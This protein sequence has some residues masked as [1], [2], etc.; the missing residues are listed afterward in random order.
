M[1]NNQILL[2]NIFSSLFVF[3]LFAQT[4]VYYKNFVRHSEGDFCQ[5]LPPQTSFI[6]YL[7]GNVDTLL[8]ENAPRWEKN[9]DPNIPGSGV[10]GVELGNFPELTPGDSVF[11]LFTC[12]ATA[13]QGLLKSMVENIPWYYFPATV[14]L[15]SQDFPPP[16]TDLQL[17]FDDSGNRE[18]FW[19]GT[20]GVVYDIYRKALYDTVAGGE[21]RNLYIRIARNIDKSFFVDSTGGSQPHGY[22][23]ISSRKGIPG[24][25]SSEVTDYPKTPVNIRARVI[26]GTTP[27]VALSWQQPE[28]TSRIFYR[29][30][31]SQKPQFY[32]DSSNL[33]GTTPH[34]YFIDSVI[35]R[36]IVYYYRVAAVNSFGIS[37]NF[38]EPLAVKVTPP[39]TDLPDL[40]VLF[41]SRTP[42]YPRFEVEYGPPPGYNPHLKPGTEDVKHY[43]EA[44]EMIKYRAIIRNSGGETVEQF[45]IRWFVNGNTIKTDFYNLLIPGQQ[46]ISQME[47]PWKSGRDTIRC[48]VI[49]PEGLTETTIKNNQII[50]YSNA[51]SF[52]FYVEENIRNLFETYKNPRGSFSFEDWAQVQIE[53]LNQFFREA[54][55]PPFTPRGVPEAIFLDTVSYHANGSLPAYGTH[56]PLALPWDGQWGFTG[57][58]KAVAYFRDVV[59]KQNGGLDWALLHELGHQLGLIDLYNMDVQESEFRV[60]EPRTGQKP[61]IQPIAWDVLYYCSRSA[62]L[63]HTNF[64]GGL[65]DHSA[66]ALWRNSGKRRGFFGEYLADIPGENI[67]FI[68]N[69]TGKPVRNA[70]ITVYQM[71]DN[72]I[73][74]IPK[75]QGVTDTLGRFLFPHRTDTLYYGGISVKNPFS[76]YLYPDPNVVGT[77]AVLFMRVA[78]GD[79][80]GYHFMDICDFNVAYWSGY[81]DTA[82]YPVRIKQWKKITVTGLLQQGSSRQLEYQL[83]PVYPNP[84]NST[85]RIRFELPKAESVRLEI[86]NVRGERVRQ[87]LKEEKPAGR[88]SYVWNGRSDKN[89]QLPSGVY[90][91]VLRASRFQKAQKLFLIK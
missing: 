34:L 75:F 59:L 82:V 61:D 6:V 11:V 58:E 46:T 69:N 13:Q 8:I 51:L 83:F 60:I 79:S 81:Q 53:K 41:I 77:N 35:T 24:P 64:Q 49:P 15:R 17:E 21:T 4:S 2:I 38:S 63:M 31:R 27:G 25:H 91:V 85:C 20:E 1:N 16:A 71:Q 42:R 87:I 90:F 65:S 43:P 14:Y 56:T 29:I 9:A 89:R 5:H 44:G 54:Q 57:D 32:P 73:P 76:S 62:Y 37:G 70:E 18:L 12:Q 23:I 33:R 48:Q 52:R 40:D 66:G 7:N 26:S 84:F 39:S 36:D 80:I 28:D 45:K 72:V 19:Q 88:Y 78:K 74:N 50:I 47:I 67:L 3:G 10:F 30:Y 86:Y 22:L 68:Q 55:Y